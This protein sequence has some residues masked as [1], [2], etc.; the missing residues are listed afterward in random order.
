[1]N[2]AP[3]ST[4]FT[5]AVAAPHTV[6]TDAGAR[7]YR[8]GGNAI[9]AAIAAAAVLT[10]TYPHNVAL[11]GDLIALVRTPDG[12]L[13]CINSSGWAGER[14]DP[15]GLRNRHGTRLPALG[16]DT[17]TVPGGVR[18]W[19]HLRALGSR[20]SWSRL[21]EDAHE[22]AARGV[23][24]ST[25]LSEHLRDP[26]HDGLV[27]TGD[28]DRV[29]RPHGRALAQGEL[30]RQNELAESLDTLRREGPDAFYEGELAERMV[31]FLK[32]RGSVLTA[33]DFAE[34]APEITEPLT[35]SFRG[36]TVATSPPNTHGFVLLRALRAIEELG[37]TDPL[38]DELGT[39][40][41]IFHRANALRTRWLADPRFA[42]VDVGH[43]IHGDLQTLSSPEPP[44]ATA[45]LVPH[46]DT[47]G[48]AAADSDG[49]GI[50]L[51]Q[52]VYGAFGSGLIDPDTGILFHNRGT[53][54]SL[55][56]TS[57]N[58]IAPRKRPAHTLMPSMTTDGT[59]VRHVLS[60][61]G[62]QGQPQIIGQLLLRAVGGASIES[63][64]SAPRAIVGL[65]FDGI[66]TETVSMEAD[67]GVTSRRSLQGRG[68]PVHEVP[69]HTEGLG[70]SN[71]VAVDDNGAM[72]AASDPRSDGAASVVNYSRH[73]AV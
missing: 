8:D 61:M 4:S 22:A 14:V 68:F 23:P 39:L 37:L 7:A 67:L 51:I 58:V 64:L 17:V 42:H 50:S 15:V 38:G 60:T 36:L 44:S 25:S 56:D 16:A 46:G 69:V 6:A 57:P 62:G 52:S 43:L 2:S 59:A 71:A 65:Q 3:A 70:Q 49:Y 21:L 73:R 13:W 11:G 29:F 63:A 72:T 9:D 5:G 41:Q 40:M 12:Q 26:E 55:E 47:V 10:V 35:V 53:G 34:F 30:L 54:F 28:F 31:R 33:T 66:T 18:G 19:K 45:E 24:V 48:I 27:G 20:L 1:M 32:K